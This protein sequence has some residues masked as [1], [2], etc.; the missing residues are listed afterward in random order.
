MVKDI[1]VVE[2]FVAS[3]L[4]VVPV[5]MGLFLVCVAVYQKTGTSDVQSW[6]SDDDVELGRANV[7]PGIYVS[8]EDAASVYSMDDEP[9]LSTGSKGATGW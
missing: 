8:R 6:A 9:P 4:C 3:I 2:I 7:M 5:A 1:S